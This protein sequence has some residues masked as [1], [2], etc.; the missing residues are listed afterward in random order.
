MSREGLWGIP[1]NP[2]SPIGAP[3]APVTRGNISCEPGTMRSTEGSPW[4][5][6]GWAGWGIVG[7]RGRQGETG[8]PLAAVPGLVG[9]RA[10]TVADNR[11][12]RL[13]WAAGFWEVV[14]V[15]TS[16]KR[17]ARERAETDLVQAHIRSEICRQHAGDATTTRIATE[18]GVSQRQVERVL[19][20]DSA[21]AGRSARQ[22]PL[23]IARLYARGLLSRREAVDAL[24]VFDY[25]D[26]PPPMSEAIDMMPHTDSADLVAAFMR[27][28]LD[29][30]MYEEIL[31]SRTN[32]TDALCEDQADTE[33][34]LSR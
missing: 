3:G 17:S 14:E 24:V 25:Q 9:S 11:D 7:N 13:D 12:S 32:R 30:G 22:S 4:G 26:V 6:A 15:T 5:W 28:L 31:D 33:A 29:A 16:D 20:A 2:W 34:P 27:G 8:H 10:R 21:R 19:R 18:L 1:G 23:D